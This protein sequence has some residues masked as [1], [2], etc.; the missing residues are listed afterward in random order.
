LR[1]RNIKPGF[2]KNEV[3]ATCAPLSRIL[4]AGLWCLADREGRL[5]DR[6]RRI[7]A[8]LLPYDTCDVEALLN[9]LVDKKD[10]MGNPLFIV[11]YKA[12]NG[13]R[14]IQILNFSRHQNPHVREPR[15]TIPAPGVS[16]AV[17]VQDPCEHS[18]RPVWAAEEHEVGPADSPLLIP[19]YISPQSEPADRCPHQEIIALY[20]QVLHQLPEVKIWNHQ[21][22]R[23]LRQRWKEETKR[24]DLT[25]WN[26]FFEFI[27]DKCPFLLG[28]N[29]KGWQADLE[30]IVRPN[31]FV[32]IIEGKY[33]LK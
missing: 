21:R 16:G 30:W 12:D 6:P 22:Q 26:D 19:E 2:F 24:Q 18:E 8:E 17:Q 13:T 1:A 20:H 10:G 4:F 14:Y 25:W 29:E 33:E 32:K 15:S 23:F 31:N 27:R 5:E 9:D 7:K 3:L 11:R 28:Q